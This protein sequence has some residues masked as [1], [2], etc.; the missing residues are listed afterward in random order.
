MLFNCSEDVKMLDA[1]LL[2]KFF[3]ALLRTINQR[4]L[5]LL[6]IQISFF[7]NTSIAC[8]ASLQ[9]FFRFGFISSEHPHLPLRLKGKCSLLHCPLLPLGKIKRQN[10]SWIGAF[11]RCKCET[12]CSAGTMHGKLS[13]YLVPISFALI[14]K[15]DLFSPL[16]D[17][18]PAVTEVTNPEF[19]AR[20]NALTTA[21]DLGL[22]TP[23]LIPA[24][25]YVHMHATHYPLW[26]N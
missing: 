3:V 4:W 9:T 24:H 2:E 19:R 11:F 18:R 8:L 5:A 26:C 22:H 6:R 21:N 17:Y 10:L 13:S 16:N 7:A 15:T 14:R 23:I 12:G 1:R 25:A 20:F